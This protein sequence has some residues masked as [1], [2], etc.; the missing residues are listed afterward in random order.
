[1]SLKIKIASHIPQPILNNV[2]LAF[3]FLY[4]MKFISYESYIAENNGLDDLLS[5]LDKVL[6]IEGDI[7][8]CGSGRCGSSIIV[9]NYLKLRRINKKVYA[10]DTFSGFDLSELQ[11]ERKKGLT[12]ATENSLK[13]TS[14]DYVK[15]KIE[16]LGLSDIIIPVKGLFQDT[17]SQIKCRFNLAFIDCDLKRSIIYATETI[18][19]NLSRNG[20]ILFDDYT[21]EDFKGAKQA[22]EYLLNEYQN[23]ISSNGLLHR[24]YYIQKK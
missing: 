1:M 18:W 12:K 5:Y 4:R 7:I 10:C 6:H 15:K 13:H 22:I 23:E 8:E 24:L 20:I 3:P 11:D 14:Y 9:A 19:P 2:F 17:L 21:T 16:R